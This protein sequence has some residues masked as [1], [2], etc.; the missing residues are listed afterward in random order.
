MSQKNILL[1]NLGSP[2]SLDLKNVKEYLL[3]FL[4]DDY[5]IDLPKLI[6]QLIIRGIILPFRAPK[7]RKAYKTIWGESGSPLIDN[8]KK[9]ANSLSERMGWNVR[10]A[11]RYQYPSIKE[12]ILFY[13]E[14]EI[15]DV[16]VVPLYPH[17][18]MSTTYSTSK[19]VD[20]IVKQYY[21]ELN[22]SIIKPFYNHPKYIYALSELIRP[23]INN[24]MDKLIF[25]Y[26]GLPERH[27]KKSDSSG[28]HCL[29][30]TLCCETDCQFS[31]NCYR[32]NALTTSKL[33]SDK[34]DLSEDKWMSAFQSRVTLIQR[35][36]LKPYTDIELTNFPKKEINNIVII[37]PSFVADCLETLEEI[38]IRGRDSFL[39]KGGK[40]FIFI[41]CLNN[42]IN[43]I[44]LLE[45]L[46]INSSE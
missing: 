35:K 4:S 39:K 24:K 30:T 32:S 29:Q 34:L 9:I 42:D 40:E 26:H 43:F 19:E 6:Q 23:Y 18:A 22:Y 46:I 16:V 8:T 12:S 44:K 7:T 41:P 3:E 45:D 5:V 25:S 28:K 21:P 2:K 14:K 33:V 20:R 37:C 36:W 1:I 38:N 10:I 11:M 31:Q 15:N 13:K 17:N 27:I